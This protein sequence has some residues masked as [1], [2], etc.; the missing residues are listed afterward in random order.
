M[1]C[2]DWEQARAFAR[3]AGGR[4][5]SEA[6]WEYAARG[7]E[8]YTYAGSTNADDVAW[9]KANGEGGTHAVC[10]KERVGVR[11]VRH[12]RQRAGVGPGCVA[13][14][15]PRCARGRL[16]LDLRGG[17]L[18][19]L[20]RRVLGLPERVSDRAVRR[21]DPYR[22]FRGGSWGSSLGGVRVAYRGR[23]GPGNSLDR[24]GSRVAR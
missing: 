4:L 15:L 2:V 13:R 14:P 11:P 7:G 17:P 20:P 5:P 10:G 19:G 21:E 3:W 18:P 1:N 24:L 16:S 23:G 12:E 9:Y 22:V 6:E 8:S